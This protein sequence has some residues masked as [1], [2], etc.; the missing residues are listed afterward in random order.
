MQSS[1]PEEDHPQAPIQLWVIQ[2]E[3]SL[4]EKDLGVLLDTKLNMSQL[5]IITAK[6]ASGSLG[7]TRVQKG[8]EHTRESL[9]KDLEGSDRTRAYLL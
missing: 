6:K 3:S 9:T 8:R 4:A 5:S 2:L 7:F 1:A